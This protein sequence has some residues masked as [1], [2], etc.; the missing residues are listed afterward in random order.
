MPA[1]AVDEL[2]LRV[3]F[4]LGDIELSLAELKAL[5]PGQVIDLAREPGNAV[6]V[7]VNG[8]RI[9]AGE[10]VEIE[11]RLGVRITELAVRNERPAS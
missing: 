6:R 1:A 11:G 9:G 5:V 8:R 10:I 7:S 3:V 4:D 2:P